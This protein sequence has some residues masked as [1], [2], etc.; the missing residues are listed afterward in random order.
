ML[1]VQKITQKQK[2]SWIRGIHFKSVFFLPCERKA[3]ITIIRNLKRRTL[4][5]SKTKPIFSLPFFR[6][7]ILVSVKFNHK[8]NKKIKT[9]T[10]KSDKSN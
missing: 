9:V 3:F 10:M 2:T 4:E 6:A 5:E 1:D 7:K 8:K